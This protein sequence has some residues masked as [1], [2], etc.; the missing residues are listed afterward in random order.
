[1]KIG[2]A[3][4]LNDFICCDEFDIMEQ[5]RNISVPSLVICGSEDVMTPVK[6]STFLAERIPGARQVVIDG[7]THAVMREKPAEYNQAIEDFL[8]SLP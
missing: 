8:A 6:Y 4:A 2:P 3:V 1:M 5:V 7:G